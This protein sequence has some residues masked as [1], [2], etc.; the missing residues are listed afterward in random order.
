[1]HPTAN[2]PPMCV[3]IMWRSSTVS[4][5]AHLSDWQTSAGVTF[6]HIRHLL[7]FSPPVVIGVQV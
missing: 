3:R 6:V 7:T 4:T 1:M 2:D 5:V